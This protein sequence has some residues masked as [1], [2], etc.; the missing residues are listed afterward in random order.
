MANTPLEVFTFSL[1]INRILLF[2]LELTEE[3]NG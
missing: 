1:T 3:E 2:N